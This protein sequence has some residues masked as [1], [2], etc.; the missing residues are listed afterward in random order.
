MTKYTCYLMLIV[1]YSCSST[2]SVADRDYDGVGPPPGMPSEPGKFYARVL[3][4]DQ[5]KTK[6]VEYVE[7]TGNAEEED[8]EV[9]WVEDVIVPGTSK[10][11]KERLKKTVCQLIQKIAWFGVL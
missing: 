8:V 5:Y 2:S 3:I 4:S 9:E 1:F 6:V 7:Y 10:W 11:E